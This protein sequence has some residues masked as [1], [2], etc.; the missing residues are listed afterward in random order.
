ME[1]N[2]PMRE[3]VVCQ[4]VNGQTREHNPLPENSRMP[5][6]GNALRLA[7]YSSSFKTSEVQRN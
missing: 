7:S 1:P 2:R 5:E 4:G 3:R 6:P